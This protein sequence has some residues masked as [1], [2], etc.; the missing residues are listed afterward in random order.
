M[1]KMLLLSLLGLASA[2]ATLAPE[3][4]QQ[5][6][7]IVL[8]PGMPSLAELNLTSAQLATMPPPGRR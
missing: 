5:V 8:G 7:G 6:P 1:A 4:R 2:A 3:P